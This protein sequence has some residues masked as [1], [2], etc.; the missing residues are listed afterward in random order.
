MK[1][2]VVDFGC[3]FAASGTL[4]NFGEGWEPYHSAKKIFSGYDFTDAAFIAKT[5]TIESR[6]RQYGEQGNLTLKDN[7]FQPKDLFPDCIKIG[8]LRGEV[9]NGVGLSGP[10]FE[11]LLRTGRWQKINKPFFLS[12][13]AVRQTKKERLNETREFVRLLLEELPKFKTRIGVQFN[14]SCPNTGHDLDDFINETNEHLEILALLNLPISLKINV[15]T[16]IE[17]I[18]KIVEGG[19][20]DAIEIPNTLPYGKF[21]NL[22]KWK[23]KFGLVSPLKKYGGGGYSGHENFLMAIK[24]IIAARKAGISIPIICGGVLSKDDIDLAHEAGANGIAFARLSI[25][26]FWRVKSIIKYAIGKFDKLGPKGANS[27]G[28]RRGGEIPQL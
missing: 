25:V 26:R 20:C 4:N 1:L 24:W 7:S 9:L 11:K 13:M 8:W 3:V 16:P 19:N 2:R 6:M 27:S 5:T 15:L 21:P 18:L 28:V 10:G 12:Y 17:A 23:K 22:V 14:I